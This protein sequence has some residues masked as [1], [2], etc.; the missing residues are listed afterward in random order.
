M[1][2]NWAKGW[3]ECPAMDLAVGFAMEFVNESAKPFFEHI[4]H[5]DEHDTYRRLDMVKESRGE[6]N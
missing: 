2:S 4:E 1:N 3:V 5:D 6:D